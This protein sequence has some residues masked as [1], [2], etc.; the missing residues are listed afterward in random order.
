MKIKKDGVFTCRINSILL[1][2]FKLI[3]ELK[4][5]SYQTLLGIMMR[6]FVDNEQNK[7][8]K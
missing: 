3:A 8:K 5:I 1:T 7:L 6:E 4:G 2:R